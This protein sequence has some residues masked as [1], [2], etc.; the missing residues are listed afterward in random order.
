M[1]KVKDVLDRNVTMETKSKPCSMASLR[2]DTSYFGNIKVSQRAFDQELDKMVLR[3][4][5][6]TRIFRIETAG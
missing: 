4:D 1:N 5:D 2:L 6:F 3:E